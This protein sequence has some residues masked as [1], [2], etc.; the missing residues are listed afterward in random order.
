MNKKFLWSVLSILVLM[1]LVII[2]FSM[3]QHQKKQEMIRIAISKEARKVYEEHMRANDPNALTREGVI[4]SYEVDTETLEYNP[5]GGLMVRLYFNNNKELDFHFGL[6][7][8]D[9]G[10]YETY[11]YTVSPK[12]SA[13]LKENV[14]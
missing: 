5:M 13:L 7:K 12:L 10:E 9:N 6:I 14:K 4:Q 11:G 8:N 1:G 3:H 2:G